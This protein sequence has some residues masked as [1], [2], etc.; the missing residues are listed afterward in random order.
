MNVAAAREGLRRNA[1]G[2]YA[3][4]LILI[5]GLTITAP[6]MLAVVP[7][8]HVGVLW[9]PLDGGTTLDVLL[10]EGLHVIFPWNRMSLYNV[11]LTH[12]E[13]TFNTIASTGLAVDVEIAVKY[14]LDRKYVTLVHKYVGPDYTNVLLF[15]EVG[16][17]AR[18][19][20][21]MYTPEELYTERRGAIQDEIKRRLV[22]DIGEVL[23]ETV[24]RPVG[25]V[26]H[27]VLIS[28]IELPA[29]VKA[30]IERKTEQQQLMM[31]Y[32]FRIQREVKEAQRKRT[33]AEGIRDFQAIV[34]GT[35]TPEYLRLRGIEATKSLAESPN[36][37]TV[38]IGGKDGLPLILNTGEMPSP[39]PS[40]SPSIAAARATAPKSA[41]SASAPRGGA[42][43]PIPRAP[44]S[45]SAN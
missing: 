25:I 18:E 7:A 42:P 4:A 20:I 34:A 28:S 3:A 6:R 5:L 29:L 31:E 21:G 37:K 44:A 38:I 8:G 23:G 10:E 32:D 24:D 22:Q 11:R 41:T 33:E 35:V 36:S 13:R 16:A 40:P 12:A 17:H 26:V 43:A 15:P 2:L 9:R 19:L 14:R 30:A 27:D 45:T 39:S 1:L